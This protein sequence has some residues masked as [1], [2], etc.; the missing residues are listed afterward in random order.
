MNKFCPQC[1]T[2]ARFVYSLGMGFGIFWRFQ[3]DSG[4]QVTLG[5]MDKITFTFLKDHP[6]SGLLPL[7]RYTSESPEG[8]FQTQWCPGP[9]HIRIYTDRLRALIYFNCPDDSNMQ[10]E[11]HTV[12]SM[13]GKSSYRESPGRLLQG[14]QV[15]DNRDLGWVSGP[16][17]GEK[18]SK[19][20]VSRIWWWAGDSEGLGGKFQRWYLNV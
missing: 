5:T 10:P 4:V 11:L 18:K 13:C 7:A 8:Y 6:N 1:C 17:S 2:S 3:G 20:T 15:K 14:V 9:L 16:G 19:G 12:L